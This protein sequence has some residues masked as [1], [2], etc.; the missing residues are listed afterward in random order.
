MQAS[1]NGANH[2][3]K[4]LWTNRPQNTFASH[5]SRRPIS[6]SRSLC[7]PTRAPTLSTTQSRRHVYLLSCG[8]G[9]VMRGISEHF[10]GTRQE[11][12]AWAVGDVRCTCGHA[13]LCARQLNVTYCNVDQGHSLSGGKGYAVAWVQ[14]VRPVEDTTRLPLFAIARCWGLR[15]GEASH[16]GP[17]TE[18]GSSGSA[19]VR[20]SDHP[21]PAATHTF[22][23]WCKGGIL[24]LFDGPSEHA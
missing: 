8:K 10:S 3:D 20:T 15:I 22:A 16:P 23:T 9:N 14:K 6:R 7:C 18:G 24:V 21:P 2:R 17:Y 19:E 5:C 11:A 1:S 13:V 4:N 12:K